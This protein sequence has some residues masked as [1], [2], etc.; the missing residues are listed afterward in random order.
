MGRTRKR[1]FFV[2]PHCGA[3]VP[4]GSGS[5]RNC[6][7]DHETGWSE[8]AG[9]WEENVPSSGYG[10]DDDFDYDEF[11]A[12]EFPEQRPVSSRRRVWIIV[13]AIVILAFFTWALARF[14]PA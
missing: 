13:V 12:G 10:G 4:V 9:D 11:V 3:A 7:S 14:H 2:C 8:A 6:G 1:D 5:C